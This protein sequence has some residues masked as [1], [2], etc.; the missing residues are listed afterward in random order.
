MAKPATL[1]V[2]IVSD[3]RQARSDLDSFSSKVAGFTAGVTSA[4]TGFAIDKIA[5]AAVAAGAAI[6]DGINKAANLSASLQTLQRNYG[7]AAGQIEEWAKKAAT[8][9]GLSEV[10]AVNAA[11]R[12]ATYARLLGISGTEAANFSQDI[13][14]LSAD[15]AAFNDLPVEDAVNAIGSAF[16]G[17]RDPLERFGIVLNDAQVKAAYFRKTGEEVNGT[18]TTQQNIIGTLAALTE[19]GATAAGAFAR[20]SD[21]LGNKQQVLSAQFDNIKT[22]IGTVLLPSLGN[23]TAFLSDELIPQVDDVVNAF[24]NGGISGAIDELGK[25]WGEAWPRLKEKLD[26]IWDNVIKWID[27]HVPSWESWNKGLRDAWD[28]LLDYLAIQVPALGEKVSTWLRENLPKLGPW[29]EALGDWIDKVINGDPAT[30][31]PSLSKRLEAFADSI[32]KWIE[33]NSTTITD[34]GVKIGTA[35]MLGFSVV[36]VLLTSILLRAFIDLK[37]QAITQG[38]PMMADAGRRMASAMGS[39]L[40]DYFTNNFAPNFAK[41]LKAIVAAAINA[42]APGLGTFWLATNNDDGG[43]GGGNFDPYAFAPVSAEGGRIE[44]N[45]NA[46]FGTNGNDVGA[47][48]VSEL[49]DYYA[50]NGSWP[51]PTG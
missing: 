18:L 28:G 36:G 50:R 32:L 16:R 30:G 44:I 34:Y 24:Q 27:D 23:V 42:V 33:Q 37:N 9:L 5:D 13:I 15:L 51:F 3:S 41:L 19:Q 25:K 10:A 38:I 29:I 31:Q 12:F 8:G 11:N 46:G 47:A 1:K 14:G 4:V 26:E 43:G 39:A 40:S 35:L 49:N 7:G 2:D 48:I 21:Q 45:V 6:S 20:E 17:E 22:K